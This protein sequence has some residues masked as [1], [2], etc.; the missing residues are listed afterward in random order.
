VKHNFGPSG[1]TSRGTGHSI[2]FGKPKPV[3][4]YEDF[5]DGGGY[6]KGFLEWAY[7]LMGCDDPSKVLH[8][9]S[10]SVI[11]GVRVDIRPERKPDIVADCRSVPLPDAS[12]DYVLADPPYSPE[13]AKNLY[14]TDA[15]YP[16][17]KQIVAEAARLL[18]PGG[19]FGLM[20]FQV[21]FPTLGMKI[22]GVYGIS[23]G[24]GYAIKAWTHMRKPSEPM[25]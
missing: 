8:L 24:C 10:G 12:F 19:H 11:T 4:H 2:M 16:L 5:P 20:H 22:Q 15:N 6:P 14:G 21:P 3:K 25:A 7:D 23:Q 1:K 18:K 17:P 9:C 13:Y